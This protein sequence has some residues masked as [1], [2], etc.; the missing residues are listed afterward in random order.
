MSKDYIKTLELQNLKLMQE[1]KALN[2]RLDVLLLKVKEL[3]DQN[4]NLKIEYKNNIDNVG[5]SS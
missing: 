1:N 3:L 2:K 4:R 5:N